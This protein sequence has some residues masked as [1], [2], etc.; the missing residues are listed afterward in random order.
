MSLKQGLSVP[1]TLIIFGG[2]VLVFPHIHS[3]HSKHEEASES[4]P[5]IAVCKGSF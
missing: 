5:Y 1:K 4:L 3:V 2:A